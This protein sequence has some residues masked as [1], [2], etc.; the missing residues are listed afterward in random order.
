MDR[1]DYTKGIYNRL[2]AFEK[3]LEQHPEYHERI[4]MFMLS[5]PSRTSVEH[6][7]ILKS[8]IDEKEEKK[9]KEKKPKVKKYSKKKT[10]TK[11]KSSKKSK[12]K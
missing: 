6:Y 4:S 12:N 3:Y 2:L 8:E 10:S 9:A 7:Q 11:K 1:L 5:V